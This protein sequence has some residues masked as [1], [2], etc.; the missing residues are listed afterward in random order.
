ES[1]VTDAT[2]PETRA[3]DH[4]R[5]GGRTGQSH[6]V[7]PAGQR[8]GAAQAFRPGQGDPPVMRYIDDFIDKVRTLPPAPRVLP[9]LLALLAEDDV[10]TSRVVTVISFDPALTANVLQ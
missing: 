2:V 1:R 8:R 6:H 10:D 3:A 9:E 4:R 7:P 5:T